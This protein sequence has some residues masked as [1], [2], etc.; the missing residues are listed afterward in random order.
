[1]NN[2]QLSH[3]ECNHEKKIFPIYLVLDKDGR[4][5]IR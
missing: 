1:M 3:E 5:Q 4:T 2:Y